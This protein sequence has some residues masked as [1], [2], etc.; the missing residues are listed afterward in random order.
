MRLHRN[1]SDPAGWS[2]GRPVVIPG[3]SQRVRPEVA[4]PM[5]GSARSPESI[6]P[7]APGIALEPE[8]SLFVI[9]DS[10]L[11]PYGAPRNDEGLHKIMEPPVPGSPGAPATSFNTT[12]ETEIAAQCYA[13][14]GPSFG[15]GGIAGIWFW[16]TVPGLGVVARQ[17]G[18]GYFAGS[19]RPKT[20][21]GCGS[22]RRACLRRD[23]RARRRPARRGRAASP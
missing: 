23:N 19:V 3:P 2:R 18:G 1:R 8:T 10:G 21:S 9:M 15:Y 22:P 6:F 20:A 7:A 13:N 14:R 5:T 12:S 4:G 17:A 11:A 16:F